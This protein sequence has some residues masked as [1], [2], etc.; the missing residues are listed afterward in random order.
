MC[1]TIS[2]CELDLLQ[3]CELLERISLV[4]Q[5]TRALVAVSNVDLWTPLIGLG[6][7]NLPGWSHQAN[8]W[9][10]HNCPLDVYFLAQYF[11][12][13]QQTATFALQ[14]IRP[15]LSKQSLQHQKLE[16][17]QLRPNNGKLPINFTI[18]ISLLQE[19]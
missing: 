5:Y 16:Q 14:S 7:R 11:P 2:T 10:L 19:G 15:I 18:M 17:I 4:M 8:W 9:Q 13:H 1:I 12:K 6:E 3:C